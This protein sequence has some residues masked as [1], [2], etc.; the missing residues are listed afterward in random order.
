MTTPRD[1]VK[2]TLDLVRATWTLDGVKRDYAM[3]RVRLR[4]ASGA[5]VRIGIPVDMWDSSPYAKDPTWG[6]G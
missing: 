4:I 3:V 6:H 1:I 5:S 2:E